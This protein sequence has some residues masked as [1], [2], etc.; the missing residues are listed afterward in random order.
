MANT[1]RD[2]KWNGMFR[3]NP[4]SGALFR[5]SYV[6]YNRLTQQSGRPCFELPATAEVFSL[7]FSCL[8]HWVSTNFPSAA[9]R[10]SV[11]NNKQAYASLTRRW[12][13]HVPDMRNYFAA[14]ASNFEVTWIVYSVIIGCVLV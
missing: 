4:A 2:F 3:S 1:A 14:S 10:R 8:A 7:C 13:C 9:E 12:R 6:K 11:I 5:L